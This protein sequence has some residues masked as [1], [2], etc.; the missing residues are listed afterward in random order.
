M[1]HCNP[2]ITPMITNEIFVCND[3][4]HD[5]NL[6]VYQNLVGWLIYLTHT[7]LDMQS[8]S[9]QD[10]WINHQK[11]ILQQQNESYDILQ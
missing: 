5:V 7:Q 8:V 1:L 10:L 3:G 11:F 9:F 2:V 4:E 6:N